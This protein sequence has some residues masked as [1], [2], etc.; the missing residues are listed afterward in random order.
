[1]SLYGAMIGIVLFGIL[2]MTR[3]YSPGAGISPA[4]FENLLEATL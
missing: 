1:V 4:A 2:V 3:P